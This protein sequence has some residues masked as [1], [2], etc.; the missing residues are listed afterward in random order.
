MWHRANPAA[1]LLAAVACAVVDRAV[2]AAPAGHTLL[3]SGDGSDG[4]CT[5][6][7]KVLP[8]LCS[9][10]RGLDLTACSDACHMIEECVAFSLV[11]DQ[12][13]HNC[14]L[15]GFD[16]ALGLLSGNDWQNFEAGNRSKNGSRLA[17]RSPMS[18]HTRLSFVRSSRASA[19][20][21]TEASPTMW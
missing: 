11:D 9:E 2:A 15:S 10:T 19:R 5:S 4:L 6:G 17:C 20:R 14:Q 12:S 18:S 13:L 21:L 16:M 3:Q 7:R 1:L 8:C